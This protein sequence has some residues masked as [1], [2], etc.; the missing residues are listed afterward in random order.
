MPVK[1]LRKII[2][3]DEARCNGCG[4]CISSCAEGALALIKGKA[5]LVKEQYCDGLAACLKECPQGA[6]SIIE[7]KAASFDEAAAQKHLEESEGKTASPACPGLAVRQF[8]K[9]GTKSTGKRAG[10]LDSCLTHWPVQLALVPTGAK[11][12]EGSDV[13]LVADCVP[14]AY[15]NLHPDFLQD[16]SVL[17]A[18][19]KLDD[20]DA[21]FVRLAEIFKKSGIKS[22]TIVHMEVPCCSG[23]VDIAQKALQARKKDIPIKEVTIGIKGDIKKA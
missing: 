7:R 22:L 2:S 12:L 9:A 15:P 19:P 13:V 21:H 18:C 11:F 4:E 10:R 5:R 8:D 16:R 1:A 17:V 3:I 14:F 23:L 20:A 6:L